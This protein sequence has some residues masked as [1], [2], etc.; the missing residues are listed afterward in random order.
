LPAI[1]AIPFEFF[2]NRTRLEGLSLTG[3]TDWS[4]EAV[5]VHSQD[6]IIANNTVQSNAITNIET[7][8]FC[9]AL[10]YR[11]QGKTINNRLG[12]YWHSTRMLDDNSDGISDL[13][14]N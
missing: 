9:Q 5:Q 3:A 12:N 2:A 7:L 4:M 6:N 14:H 8:P 1:E 11:F 10:S 13:H